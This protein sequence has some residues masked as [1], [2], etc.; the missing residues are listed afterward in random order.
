MSGKRWD[1][2]SILQRLRRLERQVYL[3]ETVDPPKNIPER[4]P[5]PLVVAGANYFI[6]TWPEVEFAEEY[7]IHLG[8]AYDFVPGADTLV[9]TTDG[10][11]TVVAA[12]PDG[13]PLD[14]D[15][16]YFIKVIAKNTSGSA[17]VEDKPRTPAGTLRLQ[18]NDITSLSA[19]KITAGEIKSGVLV[20]GRIYSPAYEGWRVEIGDAEFPLRYWDGETTKF[21]VDNAGDIY[22]KGLLIE[23][24]DFE[25]AF[26]L[27]AISNNHEL[28]GIQNVGGEQTFNITTLNPTGMVLSIHGTIKINTTKFP[29][30]QVIELGSDDATDPDI[31]G[32]IRIGNSEFENVFL[33]S[34][35]DNVL[36]F[37]AIGGAGAGLNFRERGA[38]PSAPPTNQVTIFAKDNGAGKTGLYA[39]FA[40]GAVQQVALQP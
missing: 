20:S 15:V 9:H 27:K 1:P 36:D 19:D 6:A 29:G 23:N 14:Y 8:R 33:Y 13:S 30:F 24:D 21:S 40:T 22:A 32:Y 3:L 31:F 12:D 26:L 35:F 17:P 39:R 34:R 38:D 2:T 25:F 4:N 7:D 5:D 18:D 16:P 10:T 37:F 11:V 28:I